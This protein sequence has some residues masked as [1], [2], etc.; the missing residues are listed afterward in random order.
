MKAI[1]YATLQKN[2]PGEYI[3]RKDGKILAHTKTYS[4]LI[5]KLN[6]KRIDR[7]QIVIGF[8]PPKTICIYAC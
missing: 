2:Y 1:S 4:Q 3:A 7:T 5:K 6:Q 8:V